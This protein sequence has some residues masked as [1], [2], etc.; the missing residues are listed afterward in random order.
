MPNRGQGLYI[1]LISFLNIILLVA[2]YSIKQPQASYTS[3][4]RQTVGSMGDRAGTMA[5]GNVVALFLFSSRNSVL[6]YLTD[7]SYSTYLL[8]HRWLGYWAVI[9]TVIH[10]AMLW[11]HYVNGGT[12]AA[13]FLRL[14]W[15]W[16]IVGTVAVCAIIPFPL[17]QVRQKLYELFLVLHIALSSV[18]LI[19]Y[20]Y[21]IWYVYEYDWGYEIWMFVP[22]GI[23][24]LEHLVRIGRLTF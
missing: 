21:H 13:E 12:Y 15:T 14:Y 23:W 9:Q 17:L 6:L 24:A 22:G 18:F 3:R 11:G 2:P 7:W 1:L 10:S 4:A 16:G 5:M 20:Y 8:L 19:G